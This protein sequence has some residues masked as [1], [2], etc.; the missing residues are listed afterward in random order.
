[1]WQM[2]KM[3]NLKCYEDLPTENFPLSIKYDGNGNIMNI[4]KI[5]E[6][7]SVGVPLE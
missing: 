1:M 2:L 3:M 7:Q 4:T 5:P 6:Y